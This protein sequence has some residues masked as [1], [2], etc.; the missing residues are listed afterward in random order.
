MCIS[1][2]ALSAPPSDFRL[3]YFEY[4]HDVV[5]LKRVFESDR[6]RYDFPTRRRYDRDFHLHRLENNDLITDLHDIANS[7]RYRAHSPSNLCPNFCFGHLLWSV[8]LSRFQGG[9][10]NE[11]NRLAKRI[12][13]QS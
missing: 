7:S 13:R 3:L 4:S 6:D 2:L 5:L 11:P 12:E 9:I 8:C 1:K 10:E